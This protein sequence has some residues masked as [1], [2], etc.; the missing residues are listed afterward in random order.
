MFEGHHL[1][2]ENEYH[3]YLTYEL[4]KQI[5]RLTHAELI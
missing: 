4:T 3:P 1:N 2:Y 5:V